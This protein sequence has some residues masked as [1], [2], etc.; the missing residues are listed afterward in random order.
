M[1]I[2]SLAELVSAF[3]SLAALL[4]AAIAAKAAVETNRQQTR[5]LAH[6]EDAERRRKADIDQKDAARVA[7]WT[8]LS[9]GLPTVWLIN[10]SGLPVYELTIWITVPGD[11]VRVRYESH[12][13]TES[14]ILRWATKE[15]IDWGDAHGGVDWPQSFSVGEIVCA[16]TF[17]DASNQWWQRDFEGVLSQKLGRDDALESAW[18]CYRDFG[19]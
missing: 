6:L 3:G 9:D 5:Q 16:I 19:Q 2:G 12:G 13:P 1:D 7:A 4:A 18:Q 17:R 8:G 10:E 11:L 14:R 15:I